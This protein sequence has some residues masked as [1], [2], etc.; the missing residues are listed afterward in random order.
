MEMPRVE[1]GRAPFWELNEKEN[2]RVFDGGVAFRGK[3]GDTLVDVSSNES[4][5]Q[6]L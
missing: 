4:A 6:S 3:F 2:T 1:S 5:P